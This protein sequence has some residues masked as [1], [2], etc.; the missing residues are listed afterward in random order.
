M[1]FSNTMRPYLPESQLGVVVVFAICIAFFEAIAQNS[2]K[3][4]SG[5]EDCNHLI[6]CVGIVGYIMVALMLL[7]SYNFVAMSKMNLI[8][9]CISII[10]ACTLGHFFFDE[11]FDIHTIGSISLALAA[12]YVAHL[13]EVEDREAEINATLD[14]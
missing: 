6:M 4:Y 11:I 14:K 9:S 1:V 12:I 7:T 2:L 8:W 3:Y 13:G 5:H 10:T